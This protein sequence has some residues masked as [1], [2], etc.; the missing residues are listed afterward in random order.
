VAGVSAPRE[1]TGS[2]VERLNASLAVMKKRKR[3]V[4]AGVAAIVVVGIAGFLRLQFAE[5]MPAPVTITPVAAG[6]APAATPP[7]TVVASTEPAPVAIAPVNPPAKVIAPPPPAAAVVSPP[8]AKAA[9]R[10]TKPTDTVA[11]RA[12]SS[13]HKPAARTQTAP[14]SDSDQQKYD[15]LRK[16][17]GD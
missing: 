14:A 15:A 6:K 17:W 7:V 12:P 5:P 4:A 3:M 8:A 11:A 1:D 16:A 13:H 10:E 2:L 9:P